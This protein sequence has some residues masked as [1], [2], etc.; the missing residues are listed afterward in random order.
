MSL[1]PEEQSMSAEEL[2]ERAEREAG[3]RWDDPN[4]PNAMAALFGMMG[5]ALGIN[6]HRPHDDVVAGRLMMHQMSDEGRRQEAARQMMADMLLAGF[7]PDD[8]AD[9]MGRK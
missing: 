6:P 4:N 9:L 3:C 5:R 2:I 1:T 8:L 7:S